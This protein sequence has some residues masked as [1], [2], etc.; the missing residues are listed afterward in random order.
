MKLGYKNRRMCTRTQTQVETQ[1]LN[2]WIFQELANPQGTDQVE[3]GYG[4]KNWRGSMQT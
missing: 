2:M 3:Q 1:K 4:N